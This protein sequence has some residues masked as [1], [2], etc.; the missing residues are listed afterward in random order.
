MA[1]AVNVEL[2]IATRYD[3]DIVTGK[4]LCAANADALILQRMPSPIG[5]AIP[6]NPETIVGRGL[7]SHLDAVWL[8]WHEAQTRRPAPVL[9]PPRAAPLGTLRGKTNRAAWQCSRAWDNADETSPA[10]L[11]RHQSSAR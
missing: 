3:P 9:A 11:P 1:W 8:K 5:I 2:P 7:H 4:E 6:K 10:Y